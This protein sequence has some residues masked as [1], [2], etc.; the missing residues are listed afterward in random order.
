MSGPADRPGYGNQ[1]GTN[2]A[3]GND[4]SVGELFNQV[5]NDLGV[6]L[7]TQ[8]ELA[9]VELRDE[10]VRAG[11]TAKLLGAASAIAGIT[12]VLISF[13]AAWGIGEA[14]DSP[15]LG[16]LITG[17]LYGVV[18]VVL[19]VRGRAQMRRVTPIAPRTMA[20]IKDDARW[21]RGQIR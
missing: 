2:G 21:A 8:I 19:F 4:R 5:A 6:L 18:A 10:A 12:A 11:R 3:D 13:A 20:T 16:F 7:A 1:P 15:A 17:V 14:L 9:K